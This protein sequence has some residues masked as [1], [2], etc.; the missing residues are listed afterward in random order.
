[1][2]KNKFLRGFTLIELLVVISVIAILA[3]I[4]LFGL[5]QV[6]K[7]ARDT[8]RESVMRAI[9]N[10]LQAYYSDNGNTYPAATGDWYADL[11]NGGTA[12]PAANPPKLCTYLGSGSNL[13][14]P[15]CG[16]SST[17]TTDV[18]S[19]A[20]ANNG[21]PCAGASQPQYVYRA[22]GFVSCPAGYELELDKESGGKLYFCP[23]Q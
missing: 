17:T 8:Q 3:T 4:V 6:Q 12:C 18:R 19:G 15:G 1:M 10:S 16:T 23:P 13:L 14:D 11:W 21:K 20:A 2:R 22:S 7:G 5:N 9:Q